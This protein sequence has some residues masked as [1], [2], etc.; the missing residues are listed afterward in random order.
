MERVARDGR[1]AGR[2]VMVAGAGQLRRE[3]EMENR[4]VLSARQVVEPLVG[5]DPTQKYREVLGLLR[6]S[7][8]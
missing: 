6:F 3:A 7:A 2:F 4:W 1:R 8:G 5:A